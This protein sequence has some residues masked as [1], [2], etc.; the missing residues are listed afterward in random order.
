MKRNEHAGWS[1]A[2]TRLGDRFAVGKGN[3]ERFDKRPVFG[4][5][6]CVRQRLTAYGKIDVTTSIT[7]FW[8]S[9][10]SVSPQTIATSQA[11]RGAI[12]LPISLPA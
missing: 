11:R 6:R 3:P 9:R 8:M 1:R 2:V 12:P 5:S 7:L 4:V 10:S